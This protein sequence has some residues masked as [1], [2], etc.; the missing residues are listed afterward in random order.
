MK[1]GV[2]DC[3]RPEAK[4]QSALEPVA[5][6]KWAAERWKC[7]RNV[8]VPAVDLSQD[9]LPVALELEAFSFEDPVFMTL[10]L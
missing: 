5:R 2:P 3:P 4:P 7:G 6:L 1:L 10:D 9:P 8:V